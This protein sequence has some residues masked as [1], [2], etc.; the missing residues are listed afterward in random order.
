MLTGFADTDAA[1]RALKAGAWYFILKPVNFFE[2]K[3]IIDRVKDCLTLKQDLAEE[4]V[5]SIERYSLDEIRSLMEIIAKDMEQPLRKIR[6]E[7][8]PLSANLSALSAEFTAEGFE[9]SAEAGARIMESLVSLEKLIVTLDSESRRLSNLERFLQSPRHPANPSGIE[10]F[11]LDE[12][13]RCAFSLLDSPP[14]T[15]VFISIEHD[16]VLAANREQFIRSVVRLMRMAICDDKGAPTRALDISAHR[17]GGELCLLIAG[18]G[19]QSNRTGSN[20]DAAE[21]ADEKSENLANVLGYLIER[22]S[23]AALGGRLSHR[24]PESG[25]IIYTIRMPLPGMNVSAETQ[26]LAESEPSAGRQFKRRISG[27]RG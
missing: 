2:L 12:A 8:A 15:L 6:L 4:R 17:E 10:T 18:S 21:C 5:R 14:E 23:I 25:G 11:P 26:R 13:L 22:G 27:E 19:Q 9:R 20:R 16:I 3:S 1:V 24:R 7:L